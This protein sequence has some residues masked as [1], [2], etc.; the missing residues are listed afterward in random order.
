MNKILSNN[1]VL[2]KSRYDGFAFLADNMQSCRPWN[3]HTTDGRRRRTSNPWG[4]TPTMSIMPS[5]SLL[6]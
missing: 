6:H 3:I 5:G 1:S 2:Q 4:T